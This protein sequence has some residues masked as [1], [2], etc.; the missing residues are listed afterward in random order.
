M[1]ATQ[2]SFFFGSENAS[3]TGLVR[4]IRVLDGRRIG[5]PR[6]RETGYDRAAAIQVRSSS[7]DQRSSRENDRSSRTGLQR[8][9]RSRKQVS[10]HD[11]ESNHGH[12]AQGALAYR[13]K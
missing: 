4:R 6:V 2:G 11:P 7:A 12:V 8:I 13:A 1:E 9:H 3:S 10:F 5:V